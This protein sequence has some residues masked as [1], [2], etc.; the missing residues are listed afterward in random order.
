MWGHRE[1]KS[2]NPTKRQTS[3]QKQ[4]SLL[5]PLEC[6]FLHAVHITVTTASPSCLTNRIALPIAMRRQNDAAA[7]TDRLVKGEARV[8]KPFL[9]VNQKDKVF[10]WDTTAARLGPSHR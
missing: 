10:K 6:L 9:V 1:G 7:P 5:T 3:K 4:A 8:Y 2:M